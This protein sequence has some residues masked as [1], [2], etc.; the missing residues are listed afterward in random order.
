[1]DEFVI[2]P[3]YK[4]P[5]KQSFSVPNP[6]P[7]QWQFCMGALLKY[8]VFLITLQRFS[9]VLFILKLKI[10]KEYPSVFLLCVFSL[11]CLY[12]FSNR[13]FTIGLFSI[14]CFVGSY[15]NIICS[16]FCKI[17]ACAFCSRSTADT[18]FCGN[19][20]SFAVL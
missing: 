13:P 10:R 5:I 9:A 19:F 16:S 6:Q 15:T 14:S 8:F 7:A 18:L 20:I 12:F 2:L 17:L 1:M 4:S 11:F 3:K